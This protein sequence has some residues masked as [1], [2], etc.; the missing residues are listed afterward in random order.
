MFQC[1]A[2]NEAGENSASTW[3]RVKS[4]SRDFRLCLR[5]AGPGGGSPAAPA[6]TTEWLI[7][8]D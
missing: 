6:R 4:K 8:V 3:L 2:S 1:L 5:G 7:T